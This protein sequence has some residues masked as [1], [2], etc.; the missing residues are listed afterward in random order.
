MEK[1]KKNKKRKLGSLL[2][3]LFLTVV[4]LA[5][6]TYAWF[7]ANK[8]VTI[9]DINVYVATSSGLQISTNATDWKTL[10]LNDDITAGY[11]LQ[12]GG[13]TLDD[14][15]QFPNELS[16]VSTVGTAE[17]GLLNMY[18]GTVA[19]DMEDGGT[20]KLTATKETEVK[21]TSGAFIAFDIFLKTEKA[22][23][24]YLQNGSGV[25]VTDGRADNGLQY[26]SRMAFVI[27][28]NTTATDKPYNMANKFEASDIKILE[29][30]YDGHTANGIT[31]GQLYYT[32]YG[33]MSG[34]TAGKNNAKVAYDGVK[35]VIT[36]GIALAQTNATNNAEKFQRVTTIELKDDFSKA[37]ETESNKLLYSS[38]PAGV[39]KMRVYLWIEGQDIDCEN[40]AS[41]GTIKFDLKI[42]TNAE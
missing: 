33:D 42:T 1:K 34:L 29:P 17:A 13:N 23:D 6:S 28:G 2:L 25:T 16:A 26:A 39:T 10:I 41:G 9:S 32:Q 24:L 22:E 8:T 11:T 5:T 19:A 4:M 40:N 30:N 31:N 7:T 38:F 27:E 36:T 20:F 37:A 21:G 18:K 15:N 35:D 12:D 3:L 14:K